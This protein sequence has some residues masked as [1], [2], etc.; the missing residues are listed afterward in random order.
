VLSGG[1]ESRP[2]RARGRLLREDPAQVD[3]GL[4]A[5]EQHQVALDLVEVLQ[6]G[7]RQ[8]FRIA[9]LDQ[10]DQLAMVGLGADVGLRVLVDGGDQRRAGGE[11]ADGAAV[12]DE[13]EVLDVLVR[14]GATSTRR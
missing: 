5:L 13:G 9:G 1:A 7:V 11:F 4:L 14:S 10:G 6:H 2:P 8:G 3:R 12:D